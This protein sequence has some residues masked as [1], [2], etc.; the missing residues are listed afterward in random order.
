MISRWVLFTATKFLKNRR[1]TRGLATTILSSVGVAVGVAA[2][3]VVLAV[4]NGFQLG[5][6]EDILG[7]HSYHIRIRTGEELTPET[8]STIEEARGI[9]ALVRIEETQT[10]IHG[11]FSN[12]QSCRIRGVPEDI[13]I[14]DPDFVNQLNIVSGAIDPDT[15]NSIVLGRELASAIGA[16][17]GST[18]SLLTLAGVAAG[19]YTPQTIDFVVTGI[20]ECGY[21]Q[22]DRSLA[23]VPMAATEQLGKTDDYLY[24]IKLDNRNALERGSAQI[25]N[26]LIGTRYEIDTWRNFNRSFFSA[27]RTEKLVMIVLLSLIFLVTGFNTYHSLKRAVFEKRDPRAFLFGLIFPAGCNN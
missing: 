18:A 13:L 24:G 25:S 20:F 21:Y 2:L 6:I 15:T 12:L 27:L 4:M 1:A 10:L 5:F 23:V 22:Y 3:I 11:E 7:I 16:G 26:A 9:R 17:V 8:V 14:R 19:S